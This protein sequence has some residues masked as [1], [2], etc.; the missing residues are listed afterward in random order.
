[1]NDPTSVAIPL[2]EFDLSLLPE[3]ARD[4][5][6]AAFRDAV[7]EFF[8]RELQPTAHS[9]QVA[10]DSQLIRIA[11]HG[12][13]PVDPL[14]LAVARL[15][16]GDYPR[17]VQLL[18]VALRLGRDEAKV[19]FN[20]GMALSDLGE[21]DEALD[22]LRKAAEAEPRQADILVALALAVYRK[23]DPQLA[24]PILERALEL[25]PENPYAMR[26]LAGCL[27]RLGAEAGPAVELARKATALLPNDQQSWLALGHALDA[28]GN[29]VDA[30]K[31]YR[32]VIEINPHNEIADV[33]KRGLSQIAQQ[34]MRGK[35]GGGVRPDGVMY[36]LAALEKCASMSPKDVRNVAFEIATVG[37]KGINPN[38]ATRKYSLRT[39]PGEFSG[40]QLLCYMY[41][42]W[43]QVKPEADIGFDL[44]RE[45]EEAAGLL[46][47]KGE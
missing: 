9:L 31:A 44:S 40:L 15:K 2:E 1:M 41:V 47:T 5:G 24:V 19:R 23:G 20:L 12:K 29:P 37:M 25:D 13:D 4:S 46:R 22:H 11:W 8:R 36:C 39:L 33:A 3:N 32:R 7:V 6:T 17:G 14:A 27:L 28:S 43:K 35:V 21:L 16:T 38:D 45:Y 26:N 10:I 34:T 42:T 30:E 18:R